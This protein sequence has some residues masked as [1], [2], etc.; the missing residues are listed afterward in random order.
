M[1]YS[2]PHFFV[3]NTGSGRPQ[4]QW[5]LTDD[6]GVVVCI[7]SSKKDIKA[8]KP[9]LRKC[10][11]LSANIVVLGAQKSKKEWFLFRLRSNYR[12]QKWTVP[13][14]SKRL[15]ISTVLTKIDRCW[16]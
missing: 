8:V 11:I 4:T 10:D 9:F 14:I 2:F 5:N 3:L 13:I 6:K 1:S 7:L 16:P 15:K 12:C